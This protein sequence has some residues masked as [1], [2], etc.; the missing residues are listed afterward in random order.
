MPDRLHC[1]LAFLTF[2][3]LE[4]HDNFKSILSGFTF[5]ACVFRLLLHPVVKKIIMMT[6]TTVKTTTRSSDTFIRN[7]QQRTS[8]Y[9]YWLCMNSLVH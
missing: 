2:I 1:P 5:C 8:N 4:I 3:F 7:C 6:T 9:E